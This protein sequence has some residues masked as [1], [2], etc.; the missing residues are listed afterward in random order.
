MLKQKHATFSRQSYLVFYFPHCTAGWLRE[1][2]MLLQIK[3]LSSAIGLH[4]WTATPF[5]KA[6]LVTFLR[7]A[8]G[9][10]FSKNKRQPVH[11]KVILGFQ[12]S[13][14]SV[15]HALFELHTQKNTAEDIS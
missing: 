10:L 4:L 14:E 8:D 2:V 11:E 15:V 7:Q 3:V 1:P 9:S 13:F 5:G 6:K 12:L